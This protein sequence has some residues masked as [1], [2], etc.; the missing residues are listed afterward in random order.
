V[1]YDIICAGIGFQTFG[2]EN[3]EQLILILF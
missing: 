3:V 2:D 1:F